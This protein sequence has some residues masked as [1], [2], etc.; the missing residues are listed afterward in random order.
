MSLSQRRL[1]H[2]LVLCLLLTASVFGIL[3][4]CRWLLAEYYFHQAKLK[5]EQP[6]VHD[7]HS[8]Y[9]FIDQTLELRPSHVRAIDFKATLKY[10]DW[11]SDKKNLVLRDEILGLYHSSLKIRKHWPLSYA[12]I[13]RLYAADGNLGEEFHQAFDFVADYT[14]H[15]RY[16]STLLLR[17]AIKNWYR[18]DGTYRNK[19]IALMNAAL[20]A[21]AN[22]TLTLKQWLDEENLLFWF[23]KELDQ[24]NRAI[25]MCTR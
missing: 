12:K 23:C 10:R 15:E 13:A 11:S 5:T 6:A 8:V 4:S 1:Q 2:L 9:R 14:P 20:L 21:K 16:A 24:T 3:T 22:S 25:E 18:L 17:V 19:T 7:M